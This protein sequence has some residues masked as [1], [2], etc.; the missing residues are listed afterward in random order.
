MKIV[1]MFGCLDVWMFGCLDVG[2]GSGVSREADAVS[3]CRNP[4]HSLIPASRLMPLPQKSWSACGSGVS[5]EADAVSACGNSGDSLIPASRLMPLPQKSWPACRSGVSRE[6][7]AVSACGNH[8]C[9]MIPVS[10]LT[11]LPQKQSLLACLRV[12][13]K[14]NAVGRHRS[15][16]KVPGEPQP[17]CTCP[18]PASGYR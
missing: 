8:G 17:R 7:D 3:A 1:A 11:P 6:A 15:W 14:H 10:R 12:R 2:C 9:S 5:R 13:G 16:R 18:G 4:G